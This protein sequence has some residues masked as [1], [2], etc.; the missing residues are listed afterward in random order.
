MPGKARRPVITA[1]LVTA[2]SPAFAGRQA[3]SLIQ[4]NRSRMLLARRI[5][6]ATSL[7]SRDSPLLISCWRLGPSGCAVES[8]LECNEC[9]ASASTPFPD[10]YGTE[11]LPPS[12]AFRDVLQKIRIEIRCAQSIRSAPKTVAEHRRSRG[13]VQNRL[14]I[15]FPPPRACY[16][17]NTL[18]KRIG[19]SFDTSAFSLCREFG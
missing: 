17:C 9:S 3:D 5:A 7:S 11:G 2:A 19:V 10:T 18:L 1:N 14:P 6:R 12:A 13:R 8:R 16:S 15:G 4:A